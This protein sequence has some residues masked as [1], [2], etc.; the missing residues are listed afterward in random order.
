MKI[1]VST[2]AALALLSANSSGVLIITEWMANPASNA[3]S[4]GEYFEVYNTGAPIDVSTLTISDDGSN[5][6]DLSG[7]SGIIATNGFFVFGN[8]ARV[9]NDVNYGPLSGSFTLTNGADEIVI[10]LTIGGTELARVNYSDGDPAGSGV[11]VVLNDIANQIGGVTLESNYIAEIIG[12]D[13]LDDPMGNT[14]IGSPGSAGG[15]VIP[16]PTGFA[17]L[18][19]TGLALILRRRR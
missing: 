8:S 14:D 2:L 11:A 5:S 6:I 7:V 10:S 17:L 19:L 13:T 1:F 16:E 4:V 12:N 18:G 9:H 15:T 3:D